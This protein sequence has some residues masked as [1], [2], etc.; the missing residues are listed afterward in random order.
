MP[1]LKS[2]LDVAGPRFAA[3]K[4]AMEGLLD[5]LRAHTS[6]AALGGPEASRQRH[7]DRGKL[8]PRERSNAFW[9]RAA[10]F[11]RLARWPP[12]ACMAMKRRPLASSRAS[13]GSKAGNA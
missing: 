4:A 7:V 1:V 9:T 5:E 12:T 6:K 11:L 10:L 2:S 8:L 3:N 13:A